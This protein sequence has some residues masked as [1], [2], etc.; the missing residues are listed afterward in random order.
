MGNIVAVVCDGGVVRQN[1]S[2]IG[3]TWAF[4]QVDDTDTRVVESS[5]VVTPE[6]ANAVLGFPWPYELFTNNQMEYYAVLR[7]L[8]SLPDH[9]SGYVYTDSQVTIGRVFKGWGRVAGILF[10]VPEQWDRQ[11]Q[12][13][14]GRLG[15]LTP[16]LLDGHPTKA[17]LAAGIG[18]RG[19]Q[20]SLHNVWCD[21]ACTEQAR[22]VWVREIGP[23]AARRPEKRIKW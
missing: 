19:H 1:P 18:K 21:Q 11:M 9:W 17:Q 4:C 22:T 6:S 10:N 3:G 16:V 2:P 20:T 12:A 8:D 7:A 23:T 13:Q 14:L 5:G 15:A